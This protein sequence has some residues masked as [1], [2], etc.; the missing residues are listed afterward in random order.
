MLL[1]QGQGQCRKTKGQ[2]FKA[3]PG[4]VG[5]EVP[6]RRYYEIQAEGR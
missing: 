6:H 4:G 2:G 3:M 1:P 5:R